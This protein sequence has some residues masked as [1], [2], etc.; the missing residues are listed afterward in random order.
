M[1]NPKYR[2][3]ITSE[4]FKEEFACTGAQLISVV[5]S[6]KGRLSSHVWYGADLRGAGHG[7]L[8]RIG[9]DSELIEY[10]SKV[11][12]FLSGVFLCI[13]SRYT[14]QNFQEIALETEDPPFRPIDCE[15][16]LLEIRAFDTSYF[17]I[18]SEDQELSGSKA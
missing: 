17:E 2:K 6:L 8:Q 7:G 1:F 16:V 13:D 12:Q 5:E 18:Y 14:S 11:D 4:H 3:E 10:C 15:G 9:A